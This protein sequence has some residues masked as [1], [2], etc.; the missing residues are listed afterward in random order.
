VTL[1][2]ESDAILDQTPVDSSCPLSRSLLVL[3]L[4]FHLWS[5]HLEWADL[6][7]KTAVLRWEV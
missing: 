2:A 4:V 3:V 5:M 7:D 6:T 1:L